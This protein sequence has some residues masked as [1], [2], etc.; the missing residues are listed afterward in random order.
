MAPETEME[1]TPLSD[2]PS[3]YEFTLSASLPE[4][5]RSRAQD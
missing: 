5:T 3:F 1:A 4:G 2:C